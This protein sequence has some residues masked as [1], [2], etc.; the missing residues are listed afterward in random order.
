MSNLRKD[1]QVL[2]PD[3]WGIQYLLVGRFLTLFVAKPKLE[4]L[5][6]KLFILSHGHVLSDE[7]EVLG[8]QYGE[9][10]PVFHIKVYFCL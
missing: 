8:E 7:D 6:V 4:R 2:I 3:T 10:V 9:P 5:N 1:M